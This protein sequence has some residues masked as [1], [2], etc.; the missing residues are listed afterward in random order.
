MAVSMALVLGSAA[1]ASAMGQ[2]SVVDDG[3]YSFG[4][5]MSGNGR[6]V[7]FVSQ[8]PGTPHPHVYLRD[9][10]AGKTRLVGDSSNVNWPPIVSEDG[11]Y[12]VFERNPGAPDWPPYPAVLVWDSVTGTTR[13]VSASGWFSEVVAVSANCKAVAIAQR[14]EDL[15]DPRC[16]DLK[17]VVV[18]DIQTG[19][20]VVARDD[21]DALQRDGA[22]GTLSADGRFF[23]FTGQ[24]ELYVRDLSNGSTTL[25]YVLPPSVYDRGMGWCSSISDDGRFVALVAPVQLPDGSFTTGVFRI[26]RQ[27][28]ST[29][30][31]VPL[32]VR[33]D[34]SPT[35]EAANA[36]SS[37]DD[38]ALMPP[39]GISANG[40]YIAFASSASNLVPGDTNGEGDVFVRDC[41]AGTTVRA[42][43][44]PGGAQC[45]SAGRESLSADGRHVSFQA[46]EVYLVERPYAKMY[47]GGDR[48]YVNDL[49]GHPGVKVGTPSAPR[50]VRHGTSFAV[51]GSIKPA[52]K[53]KSLA[54]KLVFERKVG[55]KWRRWYWCDGRMSTTT[56]YSARTRLTTRGS[57]RVRA[58]DFNTN[59]VSAWRSIRIT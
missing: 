30:S 34:V 12:V 19:A 20:D 39:R 51:I 59:S 14:Y 56:R 5:S 37:M 25:D 2:V 11:R 9:R 16:G 23:A 43:V 38:M 41:L 33:V 13:V 8:Y 53:R 40:R 4:S 45:G 35:G 26:D 47:T 7:A 24:H 28:R 57:F 15:S 50:S 17:C 46:S 36:G 42:N 58:V 27:A 54:V 21:A 10:V 49:D 32:A 29:P 6:W 1:S 22:G 3:L 44:G 18:R 55:S 31:S 48:V 52:H